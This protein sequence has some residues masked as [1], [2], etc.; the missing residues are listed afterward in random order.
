MK[1]QISC[2]N[3]VARGQEHKTPNEIMRDVALDRA[4]RRVPRLAEREHARRTQNIFYQDSYMTFDESRSL[5]F[6]PLMQSPFKSGS[7]AC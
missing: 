3:S 1:V 4:L 5:Y 7:I 2:F 6:L